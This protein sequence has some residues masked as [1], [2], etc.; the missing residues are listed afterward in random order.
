MRPWHTQ[1]TNNRS[2]YSSIDILTIDIVVPNFLEGAFILLMPG[3][4]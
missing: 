4:G 2:A 1:K 3:E